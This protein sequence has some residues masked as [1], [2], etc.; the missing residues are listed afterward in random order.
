MDNCEE[1]EKSLVSNNV[2]ASELDEETNIKLRGDAIGDTLYS[3]SF[4]LKTLMQFSDLKWSEEVEEDLCFL[5][6]MTVEKDVC[7]YLFEISYPTLACSALEKYTENRFIEIIIGI[8]TNILCA[9]CEKNITENEIK[10]VLRELNTD[11]HLILIQV[12]RFITTLTHVFKDLPFITSDVFEKIIFILYN[13]TNNDL[14]VKSLEA[15]S[16]MMNDNKLDKNLINIDIVKSSLIA[17]KS[18]VNESD[19]FDLDTKD[20]QMCCKYIL[21]VVTNYCAYTNLC[22]NNSLLIEFKNCSNIFLNE[23]IKIFNYFCHEENLLPITD[24]FVY[25]MSAIK[26][27]LETLSINYLSDIFLPLTKI[28]YIV[29][30]FKDEVIELFDTIVELECYLITHSSPEPLYKDIKNFSKNKAK[31]ILTILCENQHKFD[32]NLNLKHISDKFK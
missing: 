31:K 14:L 29:S 32:Y 24:E 12:V 6:D 9:D 28:L 1:S 10:I 26:F 21:E 7:K 17:Y 5:W 16:K 22:D 27:I 19:E 11:D 4:V 23:I 18:V 30:D 15:L 2:N 25:Y 13:S 20:K 3:Q 8:L